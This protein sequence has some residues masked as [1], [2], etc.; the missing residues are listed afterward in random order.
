MTALA[1]VLIIIAAQ[2]IVTFLFHRMMTTG[3]SR[4]V[5]LPPLPS[6]SIDRDQVLS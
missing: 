3:Q 5:E 4:S 6:G 2:V 1:V